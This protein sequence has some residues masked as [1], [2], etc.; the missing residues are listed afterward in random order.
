[1]PS[2]TGSVTPR[3]P[4]LDR[5]FQKGNRDHHAEPQH[6]H[7]T[8]G[9][10]VGVNPPP[11]L[12][13]ATLSSGLGRTARDE[14][15]STGL[16]V[17]NGS[18]RHGLVVASKPRNSPRCT[19]HPT[20]GCHL[21]AT[22]TRQACSRMILFL[23]WLRLPARSAAANGVPVRLSAVRVRRRMRLKERRSELTRT[24]AADQAGHGGV[25][26][27]GRCPG[28]IGGRVLLIA[29][30]RAAHFCPARWARRGACFHR[31]G[32]NSIARTSAR[33]R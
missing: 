22:L 33:I 24:S 27:V 31:S 12:S 23:R 18:G 4:K 14:P 1:M 15:T 2:P 11:N 5:C 21:A 20:S 29:M 9:H 8:A 13:L 3:R 16:R 30:I 19:A 17:P 25:L 28:G 6:R 26:V 7:E 32:H 10:T